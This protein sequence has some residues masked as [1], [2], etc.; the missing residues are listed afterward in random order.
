MHHLPIRELVDRR[1]AP[2]R[3]AQREQPAGRS[4]SL[5]ER[6]KSVM[7]VVLI[8]TAVG[9]FQAVP[10]MVRTS[11][12]WPSFLAKL[13]EAWDWALLTPA[14]LLIDRKLNSTTPSLVRLSL[15]LLLLSLPVSLIHT[16]L[17]SLLEYPFPGILWSPLREPQ[18]TRYYYV[19]SWMIYCGFV[20]VLQAFKFYNRFQSSQFELERAE[21]K[22]VESQK[23]L[24]ESHLNT[25]RLRLEPHFLFNTL[26]AISSKVVRSP[27]VAREMIEDLG[28]LLRR[29]IDYH[30][31]MEITLAQELALLDHYLAIQ[32][33]RFGKKIDI[34][35]DV[36]PEVRSVMV[37]SM[38]LQPL[39]ENAIQHGFKGRVSGG[40]VAVSARR[41]DD[42]LQIKVV[43][44]GAG[45]PAYWC[46]EACTGLGLSVTRERVEMLYSEAAGHSFT[47]E[48]GELGGTE[49]IIR[50][51]LNRPGSKTDGG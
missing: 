40:M 32:K 20:G 4:K 12:Y 15:Y 8:W 41:L 44:D 45:L 47:V 26:N 18:N 1:Q 21:K 7:I 3:V 48:P 34:R 16:G 28:A 22:L 5:I 38:L 51:P 39:I 2:G 11:F 42:H 31:S 37:P 9:L 35:I 25:L 14:V 24:A 13:I 43:D 50:I 33:L 23:K 30:G 49:V 19:G 17:A 6:M 27:E 29:S 36:E 10:D 46:M